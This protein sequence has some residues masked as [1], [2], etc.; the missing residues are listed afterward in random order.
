MLF[1]S[2]VRRELSRG[3]GATLVVVLTIVLTNFLIRTVRDAAV[4]AVAPQDVVLLLGYL[5]LGY[6]P[7]IL[8][9]S[10]FIAVVIGLGRMYRDS[11]MAIWFASGVGLTRFVRP[12]LRMS[13]PVLIVVAL[14]LL[15]VWPWG[16][17]SSLELRDRYQQ[18]GDL[19]RVTPGVFQTSSDGRRVFFVERDSDDGVNARNVFIL[20][21]GERSESVTSARSGRL[22]AEGDQRFLV[23]QRGQRNDVD[24][25][26]QERTLFS[27]EDYRV[28]ASDR[29][30]RAAESQ[31]PRVMSTWDLVQLPTARNQAELA[32]RFGLLLGS[33]NLLLLGISLSA[34]NPR[35]ASNW[36]LLFALLAFGVYYNLINLSQTWVRSEK[37][38]MGSALLV[39]HGSVFL[40]ALALLWWRDHAAVVSWRRRAAA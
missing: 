13:W 36:N 1:D 14:L 20:S 10:L 32:W 4:G 3:F 31:P 26:T 7:M 16:N 25:K 29:V 17:R 37:L 23:L 21:N 38:G 34:T 27:F 5:S 24:V 8:A 39:L 35:R 33:A 11:E 30:S 28:L 18:R 22:E 2:T 6:L 19:S 40:L 9:M 12:V 15:F